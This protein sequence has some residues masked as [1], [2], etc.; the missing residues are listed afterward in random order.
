MHAVFRGV[1]VE[2]YKT[3]QSEGLR[4]YRT[5]VIAAVSGETSFETPVSQVM[6]LGT[7]ELN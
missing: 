1:S 5:V 3:T 7:Q 6:S 2:G 4:E